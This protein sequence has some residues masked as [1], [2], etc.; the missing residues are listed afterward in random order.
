M[1]LVIIWRY[2]KVM[3]ANWRN[4]KHR[5]IIIDQIQILFAIKQMHDKAHH[6]SESKR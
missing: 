2:D 3:S 6:P 5:W 4:L 1:T